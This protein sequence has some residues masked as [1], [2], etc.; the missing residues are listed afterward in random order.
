MANTEFRLQRADDVALVTIDNDEDETKPTFFGETALRSLDRVLAELE[1]GDY[2]TAV[3]TG[4]PSFFAAGADI[5]QFPDITC[6]RAREG[7]R[8]GHELFGRWRGL[9]FPTVAAINGTCLGGGLE[10]ALHCTARTAASTVRH[11]GQPEVFLG[12][13]PAWGGT[14][15]LPRLVGPEAAVKVIVTN[16]LRQNRLLKASDALELGIVDRIFEPDGLLNG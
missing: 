5:T 14:Q 2:A 1:R 12:L 7:S 8:V 9:P 3:V 11:I 16:P 13:F 4:K 15:L 6:D 10:L